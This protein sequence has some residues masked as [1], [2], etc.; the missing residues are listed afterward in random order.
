MKISKRFAVV[1]R[2]AVS[3]GLVTTG[4]VLFATSP[5][6]AEDK[7]ITGSMTAQCTVKEYANPNYNAQTASTSGTIRADDNGNSTK[8]MQ[9]N[10]VSNDTLSSFTVKCAVTMGPAIRLDSNNHI[11]KAKYVHSHNQ[12]L[13]K[14]YRDSG[15]G[16]NLDPA[17]VIFEMGNLKF[18]KSGGSGQCREDIF[19]GKKQLPPDENDTVSSWSLSLK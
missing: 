5:A 19:V 16:V 7:I 9:F 2:A 17:Y 18:V 15:L 11:C 14:L 3:C 8:A 6:S 1:T 4:L 13:L 12:A 10:V